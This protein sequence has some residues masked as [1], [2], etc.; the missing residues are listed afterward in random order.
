MNCKMNYD[1]YPETKIEGFDKEAFGTI[2]AMEKE[3]S[4]AT[5]AVNCLVVDCYPGVDDEVLNFI[6]DVYNPKILI[7]SEDI[8]YDKEIYKLAYNSI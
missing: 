2:S 7:R 4:T 8:F 1:K 3:L 5:Q 6:Q